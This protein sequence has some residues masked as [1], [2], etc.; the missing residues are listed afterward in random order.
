MKMAIIV[1]IRLHCMRGC[2]SRPI[3]WRMIHSNYFLYIHLS[4]RPEWL[5]DPNYR[6]TAGSA[7]VFKAVI[8]SA[9]S[10][11]DGKRICQAFSS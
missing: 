4:E 2:R 10:G 7:G 8:V 1:F 5:P 11:S 6:V 9:S 3:L